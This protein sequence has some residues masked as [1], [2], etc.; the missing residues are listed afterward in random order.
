M[1][2][3]YDFETNTP[4][5]LEGEE[6]EFG[7]PPAE[8]FEYLPPPDYLGGPSTVHFSVARA[9]SS[10]TVT[11]TDGRAPGAAITT[12]GEALAFF[13]DLFEAQGVVMLCLRYDGGSDEGFAWVDSATRA[14][15][16]SV[17][18]AVLIDWLRA[19]EIEPFLEPHAHPSFPRE[20]AIDSLIDFTLADPFCAAL[21]G[22]GFGTGDY[23]LYGAV[24]LDWRAGRMSDDPNAEAVVKHIDIAL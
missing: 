19:A 21:L 7:A 4:P 6:D 3:I 1:P 8:D 10:A 23:L 9:G 20:A 12:D 16:A 17:S 24:L 22:E 2:F 5:L 11:L 14:D 18:R 13:L 15:G